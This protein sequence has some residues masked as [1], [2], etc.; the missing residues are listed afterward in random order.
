M[1]PVE[2]EF[3]P[4]PARSVRSLDYQDELFF[5]DDEP[6][7]DKLRPLGWADV[8]PAIQRAKDIPNR[9]TPHS[10]AKRVES[11]DYESSEKLD[12]VE[13][14]ADIVLKVDATEKASDSDATLYGLWWHVAAERSPWNDGME[15]VNLAWQAELASC[16]QPE[17]GQAEYALLQQ[18]T[19]CQWLTQPGRLIRAECPFLWPEQT[20]HWIEGVMDLVAFE[21]EDQTWHVIDWKT[22]RTPDA[23]VL[24]AQY[25]AQ[26]EAYCKA[27][28]SIFRAPVVGSLYLTG[29]GEWV[30]LLRLEI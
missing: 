16:P 29:S 9:V 13:D 2:P 18:S 5:R 24:S 10:L 20:Q 3:T 14:R 1:A 4:R 22:N 12:P 26:I 15:A 30:K 19:L 25:Y 21:A 23:S 17:R 7:A 11:F 8:L 6:P 28:Q 27:L